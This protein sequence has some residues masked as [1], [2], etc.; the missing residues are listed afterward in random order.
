[1]S[2][3]LQTALCREKYLEDKLIMFKSL[4]SKHSEDLNCSAMIKDLQSALKVILFSHLS[5]VFS[6]VL[7]SYKDEEVGLP[8]KL[9]LEELKYDKMTK[10]NK[11]LVLRCKELDIKL[12]SKES[13]CANLQLKASEDGAHI[14]D[15]GNI[16][17]KLRADISKLETVVHDVKSTQQKVR[18]VRHRKIMFNTII[19]IAEMSMRKL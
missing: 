5:L 10:D 7:V 3:V 18:K 8:D 1:M 4:L 17:D 14:T 2:C 19:K 12:K 13:Q 6:C 11:E 15:L 16:I 9:H